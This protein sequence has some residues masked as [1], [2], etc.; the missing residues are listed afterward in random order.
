MRIHHV[1]VVVE[2]LDTALAFFSQS[3]GLPLQERREVPEEGVEIAFLL[4]DN[5]E[6]ELIQPLDPDNSVGRYLARRG[7]GVHHICLLVPDLDAAVA[8]LEGRGARLA[9]AICRRADG[10]R[11]AFVHPKS[12]HGVLIE[13]YEESPA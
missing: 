4:L 1:A 6:L 5:S 11:Y 3:L 12:A 8:E 2:D 13:L 10:T 9:S 7:E